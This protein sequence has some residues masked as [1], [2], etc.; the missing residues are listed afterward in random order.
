MDEGY[1]VYLMPKRKC[2]WF[3]NHMRAPRKGIRETLQL[4]PNTFFAEVLINEAD[5]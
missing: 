4:A 2:I 3:Q 1:V 5:I